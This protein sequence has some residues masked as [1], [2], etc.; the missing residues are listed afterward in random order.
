MRIILCGPGA[1]GKDHFKNYLIGLGL[2]PGIST[3]TRD[4]R[5]GEVDGTT[6]HF[7]SVE[8][9]QDAVALG[10]MLEWCEFSGWMYGTGRKDFEDKDVFIMTP[11]GMAQLKGEDFSDSYIVYFC[12]PRDVR[13]ARLTE[14]YRIHPEGDTPE[15][16]L[17]NDDRNFDGFMRYDIKISD[18]EFNCDDLFR[19]ISKRI[20]VRSLDRLIERGVGR[21]A[22]GVPVKVLEEVVDILVNG[23]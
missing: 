22:T 13:E 11:S 7:R 10:E 14:R 4:P 20:M 16:R 1:S 21:E 15:R 18:P 17:Y 12:A 19:L 5:P 23:Y 9:F 6:Y 2:K 8:Q 3:T